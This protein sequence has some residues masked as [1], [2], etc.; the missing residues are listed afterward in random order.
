[1]RQAACARTQP[2]GDQFTQALKIP[3]WRG[4]GMQHTDRPAEIQALSQP[5][6]TRR[7]RVELESLRGV[8][9]PEGLDRIVRHCGRSRNL[10]QEPAV[11]PPEP[12]RAVGLTV[13]LVALLVDRAVMPAT[14]ER[15]VGER[16]RAAFGPVAHVMALAEREPA[17]R[18]AAALVPMV[19]RAPQRRGNRAGPRSDFQQA[20]VLIVPHHHPARVARQAPRR[21]L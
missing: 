6:G 18:E 4:Q 13:D 21:F 3:P 12:E 5:G 17:A 8:P 14:E 2:A 16:G 1:M 10:G 19:K 9:R 7:P 20:P 11:R 15:E